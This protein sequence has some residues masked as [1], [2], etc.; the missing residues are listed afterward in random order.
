[1]KSILRILIIL[2]LIGLSFASCSSRSG[3]PKEFTVLYIIHS[4]NLTRKA[5]Q[6][7]TTQNRMEAVNQVKKSTWIGCDSISI[8]EVIFN[9]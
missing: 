4:G 5:S 2:L 8:K 3:A 9:K 1:M 7:V 6:T